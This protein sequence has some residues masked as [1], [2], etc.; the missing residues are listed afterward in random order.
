MRTAS[1]VREELEERK[2]VEVRKREKEAKAY[3]AAQKDAKAKGLPIPGVDDRKPLGTYFHS[4]LY[5]SFMIS[6]TFFVIP[7]VELPSG[8][9][10]PPPSP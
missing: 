8:L 2:M 6:I 5:L 3:L 9:T 7:R 10:I 1:A 4:Y